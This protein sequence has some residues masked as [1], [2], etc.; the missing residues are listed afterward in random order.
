MNFVEAIA[1]KRDGSRLTQEEVATF[2]RGASDGSL[3]AEQLAA[4]LMAIC[5]RGMDSEETR[6][7]TEEMLNSGQSWDF[8]GDR[9][10]VVDKHSTG[11]V[12]DTVSLIWRP[13]WPR[14]GCRSR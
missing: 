1:G 2:V 11:G 9:P 4:M 13:C 10:D 8:A 3:P 14:S 6:W 7:L 12:G 5:C